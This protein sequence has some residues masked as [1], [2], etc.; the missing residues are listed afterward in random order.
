MGGAFAVLVQVLLCVVA[1]VALFFKWVRETAQ[2]RHHFRKQLSYQET[3]VAQVRRSFRE[4]CF[5]VSKQGFSAV[6]SHAFN[7]ILAMVLAHTKIKFH[8]GPAVHPDQCAWYLIN[9]ICDC[10]FG[11]L[12][13]Y[14]LL[15]LAEATARRLGSTAIAESG[16]YGEPGDPSVRIWS[17]QCAI[18]V[19]ITLVS[20]CLL[21][22]V[23]IP[24]AKPLGQF[25]LFLSQPLK[26]HPELELVIVMVIF[27]AFLNVFSFWMIDSFLQKQKGSGHKANEGNEGDWRDSIDPAHGTKC[28]ER[29]GTLGASASTNNLK[30]TFHDSLHFAGEPVAMAST[31]SPARSVASANWDASPISG[32][33]RRGSLETLGMLGEVEALLRQEE[34][35]VERNRVDGS[36][37]RNTRDDDVESPSSPLA[38]GV[39]DTL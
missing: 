37:N 12:L 17:I 30:N 28:E 33:V 18:F 13:I 5:D 22:L 25:G 2:D 27:P 19:F 14:A 10:F 6:V 24:F 8:A 11:V 32:G 9:Y 26:F 31:P 15:K 35:S 34:I 23:L 4:W 38:Y 7:I 29:N 1:F 20:K 16:N 3:P 21:A 36:I 39:T